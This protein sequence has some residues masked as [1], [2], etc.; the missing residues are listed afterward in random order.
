MLHDLDATLVKLV[1]REVDYPG[2]TVSFAVPSEPFPASDAVAPLVHFFLYHVRENAE[3]RRAEPVM[4]WSDAG[5]AVVRRAPVR[6]DCGYLVTAW[7][8]GGAPGDEH[9]ILGA[10]LTG[11]L[12]HRK[13]PADL[14]QGGL[15]GQE[16]PV[17]ASVIR[18]ADTLE[19]LGHLWRATGA[20]PRAALDYTL[21]ISVEVAEPAEVGPPV[22]ENV[23][24]LAG[25]ASRP[26]GP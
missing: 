9:R 19:V 18:A 6:V 7:P 20:A 1:E 12:R 3:L 24:N 14:L 5:P 23:I 2:L 11:L 22:R 26:P 4:G 15:A 8:P 16:P 10:V 13:L 17:R 21:T 25:A